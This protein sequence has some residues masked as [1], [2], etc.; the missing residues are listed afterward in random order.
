M[1]FADMLVQ[2]IDIS[3]DQESYP[4]SYNQYG[5]WDVPKTYLHLYNE[6]E[7]VLDLRIPLDAFGGK[8]ALEMAQEGFNCHKTQL[9]IDVARVDDEYEYSCAWFGLY[10]SLVGEDVQKNDIL[11]NITLYKDMEPETVAPSNEETTAVKNVEEK[12]I[13]NTNFIIVI[14]VILILI[15]IIFN[16]INIK[17][18]K[19]Y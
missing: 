19:R 6:N 5:L 13:Y 14:I 2:A 3:N 9:Y 8:T 4:E 10:R 7:I 16:I 17:R 18:R 11:E 12:G 1:L 15:V